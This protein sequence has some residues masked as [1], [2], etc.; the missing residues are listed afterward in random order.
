MM[1]AVDD[2]EDAHQERTVNTMVATPNRR[3]RAV[4][5]A[6]DDD[7]DAH[8]EPQNTMVPTPNLRAPTVMFAVDED[9]DPIQERKDVTVQDW[10]TAAVGPVAKKWAAWGPVKGGVEFEGYFP[11]DR[12]ED[13]QEEVVPICVPLYNEDANELVLTLR[14]IYRMQKMIRVTAGLE[15]YRVKVC[16]IQDGFAVASESF[17][18]AMRIMFPPS[19]YED[20]E[21]RVETALK[22][23]ETLTVVLQPPRDINLKH[24]HCEDVLADLTEADAPDELLDITVV[25]KADNRK[26]INSHD[27]FF[28]GFAN[29]YN[30]EFVFATDCGTL[31]DDSCLSILLQRIL[32]EDD[33]VAVTGRQRV[34]TS[35]MQPGSEG[36]G[37]WAWILRNV[38]GY[39][40]EASVVLFNGCF[41]LLGGLPVIPGPCGLFRLPP[42][43]EKTV[44]DCTMSPFEFYIEASVKAEE[45][46]SMLAGNCMLAE[47]RVLT[48]AAEFLTE[49]KSTVHW[50]K[51]ALFYFQAET[52]LNS[53]VAQ[54]RRWLNGTVAGYIYVHNELGKK[55]LPCSHSCFK[56]MILRALIKLMLFMYVGIAIGPALY[57]YGFC[58]A[59]RYLREVTLAD[60]ASASDSNGT[61]EVM[62][63]CIAVAYYVVLVIF[64]LGHHRERFD[65]RLFALAGIMNTIA[66]AFMIVAMVVS[67]VQQLSTVQWFSFVYLVAPIVLNLLIPNF[68]SLTYLLNPLRVLVFY[69]FLPTMQGFFLTLSIARTFD[70][71]W[72]NRAGIGAE[73]E[74]LKKGTQTMMMVQCLCNLFLLVFFFAFR[75]TTWFLWAQIGLMVFLLAPMSILTVGSIIQEFGCFW[76]VLGVALAS[77]TVVA[78]LGYLG[79]MSFRILTETPVV[80]LPAIQASIVFFLLVLLKS[81][82][83]H[84]LRWC[85]NFGTRSRFNKFQENMRRSQTLTGPVDGVREPPLKSLTRLLGRQNTHANE[86]DAVTRGGSDRQAVGGSKCSATTFGRAATFRV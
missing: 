75:V 55:D 50:A 41:S 4:S 34:M 22:T 9:E 19:K 52:Q 61:F 71:S 66:I 27:L 77:C 13:V 28:R 23:K 65:A 54:R 5:F 37:L 58:E 85:C 49:G 60:A 45:E 51:N 1:F 42:L 26:K 74:S 32:R 8:Q 33:C 67:S 79:D 16:I 78:R 15:E 24:L 39:D 31:F 62:L 81:F 68:T 84:V 11:G 70:L 25:I 2:N 57:A 80:D 18:A 12:P 14:S 56:I 6:V 47:D 76:S 46:K 73:Q 53:L 64:S 30:P 17:K 7:E 48:F 10:V 69:L 43:M 82:F 63:I 35:A 44:Q 3:A 86:K 72:G 29:H 83:T 38:Q 36:E 40:Y 20:W 21:R 59:L